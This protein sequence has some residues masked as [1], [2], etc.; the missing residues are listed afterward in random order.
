MLTHETV[1][2]YGVSDV[3]K[4]DDLVNY[5]AGMISIAEGRR[6]TLKTFFGCVVTRS[7]EYKTMH[8]ELDRL[9]ELYS[10][11]CSKTEII[12]AELKKTTALAASANSQCMEVQ[13]A[14][15]ALKEEH[16][17]LL[18][19]LAATEN[20]AKECDEALQAAKEQN[21]AL[22]AQIA[23]LKAGHESGKKR[24]AK[25]DMEPAEEPPGDASDWRGALVWEENTRLRG[26]LK[27]LSEVE[28]EDDLQ[29][30]KKPARQRIS[31]EE[32]A[33]L[34]QQCELH[35]KKARV[36]LEEADA[37]RAQRDEAMEK[38]DAMIKEEAKA[39]QAL[40]ERL[41]ALMEEMK[42]QGASE[43]SSAKQD[44]EKAMM[45][46]ILA[47][48]NEIQ[49]LKRLSS[50][51]I[52]N[53]YIMT[54][55]VICRSGYFM[56]LMDIFIH[57]KQFPSDNEGTYFATFP[58][59]RTGMITSLAPTEMV[60]CMHRVALDLEVCMVPPFLFQY[61][62]NSNWTDFNF[63][64]QICITS[65]CCKVFRSG[66]A[67]AT[68]VMPVCFNTYQFRLKISENL[69]EMAVGFGSTPMDVSP[70]YLVQGPT[71]FFDRWKFPRLEHQAAS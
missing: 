23:Q 53:R 31:S 57:W 52:Q 59:V 5:I 42:N 13:A 7:S 47:E 21:E 26:L 58:C 25:P 60:T 37:A 22:T 30:P 54:C 65:L 8:L 19:R 55:P 64:D 3:A 62:F 15:K 71:H 56:P 39:R 9:R 36:L 44:M 32:G 51:T 68:E 63:I 70:V 24:K 61:L 33:A 6:E 67:N 29:P 12:K 66:L 38:A 27:V 28:D 50:F 35:K 1:E 18:L 46:N 43:P 69:V 48:E 17:H 16:A 34:R 4:R 10:N 11:I 49:R 41:A 20:S 40:E 45:N 2:F 14:N